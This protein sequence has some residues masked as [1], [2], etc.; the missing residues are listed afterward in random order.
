MM[1]SFYRN[2]QRGHQYVEETIKYFE[3]Q[4]GTVVSKCGFFQHISDTNYD[5]SPD[6]I[7][8]TPMHAS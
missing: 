2:M 8:P 3:Q 1:P 4:S 6:G 5:A 7:G